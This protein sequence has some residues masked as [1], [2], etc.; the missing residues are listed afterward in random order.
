MALNKINWKLRFMAIKCFLLFLL[1]GKYW[2]IKLESS[3][4]TLGVITVSDFN[5]SSNINR[6]EN[7]EEPE[8]NIEIKSFS[9]TSDLV[10]YFVSIVVQS[11]RRMKRDWT[12]KERKNNRLEK[13]SPWRKIM[14]WF[15]YYEIVLQKKAAEVGDFFASRGGVECFKMVSLT[16]TVGSLLIR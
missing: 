16:S 8:I 1:S 14:N 7:I 10:F 11:E 3:R 15:I 4:L 12:R 2:I 13:R 9:R 5:S 6:T